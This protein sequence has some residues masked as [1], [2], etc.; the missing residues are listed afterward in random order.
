M[1][2]HRVARFR[3]HRVAFSARW[4]LCRAAS[5]CLAA[6]SVTVPLSIPGEF[7]YRPPAPGF[8]V[9]P[10]QRPSVGPARPDISWSH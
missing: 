5:Q 1:V 9:N 2:T 8:T 4:F 6:C 10:D 7:K 3:V